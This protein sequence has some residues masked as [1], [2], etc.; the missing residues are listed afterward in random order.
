MAQRRALVVGLGISGMATALSLTQSGW[1]ILVV[2][3]AA[4]RRTGGYFIGLF[5]EGKQA[6]EN[7][8]IFD[9][10][11]TRN[12]EGK[13]WDQQP[14]GTQAQVG[15]FIDQPGSPA[16]LL[17]GDVEAGLWQ[18]IEGSVDIRFD[19]TPTALVHDGDTVLVTLKN[20]ATG[21]NVTER[22]DLVV[23]ADGLRSTVRKLAFG[24]H[25]DFL[26]SMD[27]IICAYEFQAQVPNYQ[28]QDSVVIAEP[29]RA[30]WVFA[31][32]DR[33]PTALFTYRTK[34]VDAEFRQKPAQVLRDRFAGLPNN[35]V[36]QHALSELDAAKESLFDSV[37]QVRMDNWSKGRVVLVGDAAWCLTLYSGMGASAGLKGGY[38]LGRH[39]KNESCDI[40]NALLMWERSLRPLIRKHQRLAFLKREFFV[41]SSSL[42][43]WIRRMMLRFMRRQ[44]HKTAAG[45]NGA[46]YIA[47]A[48]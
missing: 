5:P 38:E 32:S 4:E 35:A 21:Q 10:I 27:A 41:P 48:R 40:V 13:N 28:E 1:D 15:G 23:G 37:Q 24:P 16:G 2:E 11:H 17:R 43:A 31:F 12:A 25:E 47:K 36:L 45:I 3:K 8:G 46:A 26:L 29:G 42:A 39:L 9:D 6:A 19:T 30:L 34:D 20:G 22:F 44:A 18:G 7:L 14:D 33:P